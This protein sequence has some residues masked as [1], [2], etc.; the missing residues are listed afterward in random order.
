M[1]LLSTQRLPEVPKTNVQLMF[2]GSYLMGEGSY[3][4]NWLLLDEQERVCRKSWHVEVRRSRAE[5]NVKV[6]MPGDAVW[7][8]GL[9]GAHLAPPNTDD[10]SPIRLTIL[11]NA[12]PLFQHRTRLGGRDIGTLI[13]AVT[14]LLERVPTRQV[15]LVTFN[16]EQQ[17]DLYR[18]ANFTLRNMPEVADAMN[19]IELNTVDYKVLQNRRGQGALMKLGVPVGVFWLW[20]LLQVVSLC[21]PSSGKP[22][23]A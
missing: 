22:L 2:G 15:R 5:R 6:G 21:F 8:V 23:Y 7:D 1:Y 19:G 14:S 20:H 10:A 13:S 16:L 4:V 18:N 17:K 3:D 12:A 9:R 11:L